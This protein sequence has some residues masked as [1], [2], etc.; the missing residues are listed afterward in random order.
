MLQHEG[1]IYQEKALTASLLTHCAQ[2]ASSPAHPLGSSQLLPCAS[3]FTAPITAVVWAKCFSRQAHLPS[4]SQDS[5]IAGRLKWEWAYRGAQR[6]R[7]C[8]QPWCGR[9]S[10]KGLEVW[11]EKAAGPGAGS[12]RPVR[13]AQCI[14][15]V[16]AQGI[17]G[18]RERAGKA[19]V[20][21]G[22]PGEPFGLLSLVETL[23]QV[24]QEPPWKWKLALQR[25][26][27]SCWDKTL[28]S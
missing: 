14:W 27:E 4:E 28:E 23:A 17:T 12:R 18:A 5:S 8:P 10:G 1:Q 26:G 7:A 25:G 16:G 6:R 19:A 24:S 22:L 11:G 2:G 21:L 13:D 3:H 9:L 20:D 15:L